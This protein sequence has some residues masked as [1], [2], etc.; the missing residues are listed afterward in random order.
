MAKRPDTSGYETFADVRARL[1][2]IVAQVRRKD[3]PLETSLDLFDEAVALAEKAVDFVDSEHS[4]QLERDQ[5]A[6]EAASE[7][8]TEAE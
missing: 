5:V 7:A 4:T 6:E 2:E 1:D 3:V 8:A